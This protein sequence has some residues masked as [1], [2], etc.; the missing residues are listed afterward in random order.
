MSVQVNTFAGCCEQCG[1]AVF[2]YEAGK[3]AD[4]D[5]VWCSSCHK[6][7]KFADAEKRW[8][9]IDAYTATQQ[10]NDST[11]HYRVSK[12]DV[13]HHFLANA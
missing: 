6:V 5:L 1:P 11:G 13:N 9:D 4:Q 10:V 12:V 8:H 7:E 2:A 3:D